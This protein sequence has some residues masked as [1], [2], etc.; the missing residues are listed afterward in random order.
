MIVVSHLHMPSYFFKTFTEYP[1]IM[2][3]FCLSSFPEVS[4]PHTLTVLRP[5]GK[6]KNGVLS[7]ALL[8]SG[9]WE[10]GYFFKSKR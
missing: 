1:L 2:R 6:E 8:L 3:R 4:H 7:L 10:R 5:P 9:G